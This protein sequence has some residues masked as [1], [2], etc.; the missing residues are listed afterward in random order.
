MSKGFLAVAVALLTLAPAAAAQTAGA[1][2][3]KWEATF[4]MQRADGTEGDP[5]PVVFDLTQK[6][7][8]LTGTADQLT[9]SGRSK[10]A[11]STRERPRSRCS[12]PPA[13]CSR[14][15][16]TTVKGRLQGGRS[17][18]SASDSSGGTRG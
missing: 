2:T 3:G 15:P 14:S 12:S 9:G 17:L 6:G 1:F 18:A 8:V 10:R 13:R 16:L 4:K 5:R 11:L 7:K